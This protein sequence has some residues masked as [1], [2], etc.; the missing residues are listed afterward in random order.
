LN[1]ALAADILDQRLG[2]VLR[3]L[4]PGGRVK[5]HL[6]TADH[7]VE[8]ASLRLPG[9]SAAVQRVP[10]DQD[11][12]RLLTVRGFQAARITFCAT[13]PSFRV[14]DTGI[15]RNSHRSR[16]TGVSYGTASPGLNSD[17]F[18]SSVTFPA[19][20]RGFPRRQSGQ[21]R[22]EYGVRTYSSPT[23]GGWP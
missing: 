10:V 9:P 12:L 1:E 8:D 19:I 23:C 3:V 4:R 16:Q 18:D 13:S 2:E 5:M 7:Q 14:G 6:L 22:V 17:R 15:A 21:A 11:L 20:T